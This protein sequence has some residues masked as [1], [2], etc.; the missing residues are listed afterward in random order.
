MPVA[1]VTSAA[2]SA[3]TAA[4]AGER[5]QHEDL[6]PDVTVEAAE[7]ASPPTSR[8]R[9]AASRATAVRHGE[10]ELR[11]VGTGGDV[12]VGVRLDAGRHPH[13]DACAWTRPRRRAPRCGRARRTSR[14]RC[15]PRRCRARAAARRRTCCC[16]GTRSALRGTPRGARPRAHPR[17]P[18]R[19]GALRR[20]PTAPSRCRGTPSPRRTPRRRRRHRRTRGRAPAARSRST[21]TAGCRARARA[22]S[23]SHPSMAR[24]PSASTV[25]V[26]GRS[27]SASGAARVHGSGSS[28]PTSSSRVISSG[29]CT[30]RIASALASPSRHASPNHRRACVSAASSEMTRQSR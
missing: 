23:R 24:R 3:T 16:R 28:S 27:P 22:A 18:R 8:T 15:G 5:L 6:R 21:R 19:G 9:N 10:P 7:A 4:A 26:R 20:R 2:S 17:W 14:R 13:E 12:L 30:P 1:R 11:V 29:A 25:A